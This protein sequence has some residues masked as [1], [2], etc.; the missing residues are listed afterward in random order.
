[1]F[2]Q[3]CKEIG[4][5]GT[6]EEAKLPGWLL[7]HFASTVRELTAYSES[8][9]DGSSIDVSNMP[10]T[11]AIW[12][13]DGI[14]HKETDRKPNWDE[15]VRMPNSMDWLVHNRTNLGPNGWEK[16][17]GDNVKCLSMPGNHFT[18]MRAPL[19]S[20]SNLVNS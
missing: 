7:P 2:H 16:L 19:V 1:M 10:L 18:M 3:Y 6:G 4:L 15:S 14:V 11:V 12:A 8:L 9:G 20:P 13:R 17:V 5:L